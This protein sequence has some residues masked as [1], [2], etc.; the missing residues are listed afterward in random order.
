MKSIKIYLPLLLVILST[1]DL[2]AQKPDTIPPVGIATNR[3]ER[4]GYV[5][6]GTT[7]PT[8]MLDVRGNSILKGDLKVEQNAELMQEVH[9][10]KMLNPAM[11]VD[12]LLTIDKEGKIGSVLLEDFLKG[13]IG[14]PVGVYG[15]CSSLIETTE[16]GLY[17]RGSYNSINSLGKW[18]SGTGN[19]F[20][21]PGVNVGIGITNPQYPLHV[22]GMIYTSQGVKYAD[23]TTQTTAFSTTNMD[24]LHLKKYLK[25]GTSSLII[26]G[27][28][29]GMTIGSIDEN[30][31]T[32]SNLP[33]YL[34]N[35]T[36]NPTYIN[37]TGGNVG[38][39]TTNVNSAVKLKVKTTG[40][41]A[42]NGEV[43]SD[44]AIAFVASNSTIGQHV[45]RVYGNG[46]VMC[47]EVKVTLDGWSDYVFD[48]NYKL[49]SLDEV[50][51]YINLNKHLPD[52][53]SAQEVIENGS[54]LGEM[55]AVLLQKIE[56]LYLYVLQMK[57][58]N[59]ALK[60]EVEQLKK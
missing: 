4:T 19:V 60:Q 44:N 30:I 34:Q 26:G 38:I 15:P 51:A 9:L 55:D 10:T 45:F 1:Y 8:E 32:T 7:T 41:F 39:G 23:G 58:E 16:T 13:K 31:Y 11:E 33:L 42:I 6:A 18:Q 21:C 24:H 37:P 27:N 3:L 5:G 28:G 35:K 40:D 53:P 22:L 43:S 14:L 59:D 56:E 12:R 49:K 46:Q 50:E 52:V 48:E 25:V 54:N 17:A 2:L 36:T 57:K 47:K 20:V 29:P